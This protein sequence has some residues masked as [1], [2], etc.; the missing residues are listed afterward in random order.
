VKFVPSPIVPGAANA[1]LSGD[2]KIPGQPYVVRNRFSP[3]TFSPPHF[4]PET[5]YILVLKGTWWVG[6]GPGADKS[7]T[8]PVPAG[9]F[10]VHHPNQIHWDG[11]KDEEVIVQIMGIGPSATIRSTSRGSQKIRIEKRQTWPLASP[12]TAGRSPAPLR[13]HA[14]AVGAARGAEAHRHEVR[15]R[16]GQCGAAWCISRASARFPASRRSGSSP[17]SP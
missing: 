16:R 10:V 17:G 11:A 5:R 1:V 7:K 6:S 12:S 13:R 3:G 4:H 9:S 15:L 14:A 8:T 2:P